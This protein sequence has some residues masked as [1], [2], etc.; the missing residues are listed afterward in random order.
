MITLMRDAEAKL[1]EM[2]SGLKDDPK[3]FYAIQF[4]F[5]KLQ[6][7]HRTDYQIKIAVNVINDLFKKQEGCLFVCRDTDIFVVY[8]GENRE[9]L[10][11]LIYQL[12][13]LLMDDP[14][15]Y[16]SHGFENQ[17]FSSYFDLAFQW[18]NFFEACKE[19]VG[20]SDRYEK[21]AK[22]KKSLGHAGKIV[23]LAPEHLVHLVEELEGFDISQV[24][25]HQSVCAA[26]PGKSAVKP[27]FS[28]VYISMMH[29]RD[30]VLPNVDLLA[31]Y[32]LFKYVTQ[33]LDK[34]VMQEV[35]A[36]P[37]SYLNGSMSIN[38]NVSTLLSDD[39]LAFD[40]V[41]RSHNKSSIVIEIDVADVF[42]NLSDFLQ[43]RAAIQA[44][45]YRIC[46]DALDSETF[47]QIDREKIG[48]NLA[49][50]RWSAHEGVRGDAEKHRMQEAVKR[51][52]ANRLILVRCDS[53]EAVAYGQSL[54]IYLFQGRYLDK[55]VDPHAT[56]AN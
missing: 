1:L 11:K 12:R 51:W 9:L 27:L 47:M 23:P 26:M 48:C 7:E 17:D 8:K 37:Q 44:L 18:K 25:R 16:S 35:E 40:S 36:K 32:H 15:A 29:L 19:K 50:L 56:V 10:E 30:K 45:G 52:G 42:A 43:A 38:L 33:L 31:D 34:K 55:I 13:Y 21:A 3:G 14:L 4:H 5:A 2:A 41:V 46:L 6:E 53:A 22:L 54:G 28:E 20:E 24:L 49:K 39:F